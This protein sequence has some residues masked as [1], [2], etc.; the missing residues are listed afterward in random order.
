[1][2]DDFVTIIRDDFAVTLSYSKDSGSSIEYED[3]ALR[4]YDA[5]YNPGC[6]KSFPDYLYA[7]K[8]L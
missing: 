1:M 6:H 8:L 3:G 7:C 4:Y 2:R 5:E